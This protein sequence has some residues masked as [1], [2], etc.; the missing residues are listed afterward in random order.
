M[1]ERPIL[2]SGEMVRAILEGRKSQTRRV[3]VPQPMRG[4]WIDRVKGYSEAWAE[5]FSNAKVHGTLS[6]PY[7]EVGDRLWVREAWRKHPEF[8]YR[9]PGGCLYFA[10]RGHKFDGPWKPSIH[11][12]RWASRI[13]LEVTS[14][15]VER[16]RDISEEDAEA[17]GI[18]FIRDVPDVDETLSA[19]ELFEVLWDSI[20]G[21]RGYGW[22]VN[23]WVWVVG[24]VPAKVACTARG[25]REEVVV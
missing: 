19:K 9:G 2:F 24:F 7:G 4:H 16:L 6:C 10:D 21:K 17:E 14:I 5:Y 3:I 20:N 22:K 15:R 13:T 12:P 25:G 18:Q 11:M 23:P 1:R 8:D